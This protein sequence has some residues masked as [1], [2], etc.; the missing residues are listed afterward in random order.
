MDSE[1]EKDG[2]ITVYPEN[3]R[4]GIIP[5]DS[6][7][8]PVHGSPQDRG[9]ADRYYGRKFSPHWYPEGTG[10]GRRI[11]MDEMTSDQIYQYQYGWDH[12]EDRKDWG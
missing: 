4:R 7:K 1:I 11:E 10:F 2:F 9:S 3:I 8:I 5:K 12:E 6:S